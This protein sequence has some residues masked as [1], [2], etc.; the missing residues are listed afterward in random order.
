L[1][2]G[3]ARGDRELADCVNAWIDLKTKDQ[4]IRT[5]YDYWILGRTGV[6]RSPRWSVIRNVLHLVR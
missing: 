4:T 6:E 2:Y 5:L 1:A 3:L